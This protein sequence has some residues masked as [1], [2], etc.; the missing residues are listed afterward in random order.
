MTKTVVFAEKVILVRERK[1][2]SFQKLLDAWIVDGGTTAQSVFNAVTQYRPDNS[3]VCVLRNDSDLEIVGPYKVNSNFGFPGKEFMQQEL[4]PA[5]RDAQ[6]QQ[7]PTAARR[8]LVADGLQIASEWLLLPHRTQQTA[9]WCV[10]YVEIGF[11]LPLA[12]SIPPVDNV[13]RNLLQMLLEGHA[14]K[15]IAH[16]VG[17]SHRTVEHRFEKLKASMGAYNLPHLVAL[18]I[19]SELSGLPVARLAQDL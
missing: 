5:C 2:S 19:A 14:T 4:I 9:G 15:E 7:R 18:S 16:R 10:G 11:L 12:N 13:D 8:L 17:M 1:R 3:L 6:R